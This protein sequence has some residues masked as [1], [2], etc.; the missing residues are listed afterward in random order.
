[1]ATQVPA[2]YLGHAEE[3]DKYVVR[4]AEHRVFFVKDHPVLVHLREYTP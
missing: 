4:G 2:S 1:M 3:D